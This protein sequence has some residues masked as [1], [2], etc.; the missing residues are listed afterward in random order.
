[1]ALPDR[2][3]GRAFNQFLPVLEQKIELLLNGLAEARP[4]SFSRRRPLARTLPILRLNARVEGR[5]PSASI[6]VALLKGASVR[7]EQ[8]PI[9]RAFTLCV[10]WA[11]AKVG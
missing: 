9:K 8:N 7:S 3:H 10:E 11:C 2:M 6:L 4:A 1:V 5:R